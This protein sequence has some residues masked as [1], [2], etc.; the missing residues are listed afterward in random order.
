MPE[1]SASRARNGSLALLAER[2][3]GIVAAWQLYLLGLSD[4]QVSHR[5]KAGWLH[6][7]HRGVYSVGHRRI[8]PAGHWM[9]AVLAVARPA[10]GTPTA[11]LSHRSAAA[12]WTLCAEVGEA[13]VDVTVRGSN[14]K[15]RP[16]LRL[17]RTN[18]LEDDEI[19]RRRGIPC[20]TAARTLLDLGSV[21]RRRQLER[22]IDEAEHKRLCDTAEIEKLLERYRGRPGT[23]LLAQVLGGHEPGSTLTRS[24]LEERFLA[25][26]RNTELP[27]PQV[28][29]A[30]VGL[31]VDFLWPHARLVVEVDG[32]RSH[33]TRRAFQDDRD[34]D[35]LLAANGYHVMRFT[36]WDVTRRPAVVASRV[37]RVLA[38]RARR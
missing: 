7:M 18:K 17:H 5:V 31:T 28:N 27:S 35:T 20:T 6:R 2:Q 12:L 38:Q 34:R 14:P 37:A 15:R 26:C 19:T 22:A 29:A 11:V 21:L 10:P 23:A 4:D 24:E 8:P 9:A 1:Q 25:V 16:G 32:R 13:P 3:H 36:W 30:L 33:A